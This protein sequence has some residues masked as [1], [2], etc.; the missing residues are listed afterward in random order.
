[1]LVAYLP[2]VLLRPRYPLLCLLAVGFTG[3]VLSWSWRHGRARRKPPVAPDPWSEPV[4]T[5]DPGEGRSVREGRPPRWRRAPETLP[6]GAYLFIAVVWF[7][8]IFAG[9]G[10]IALVV[11]LIGLED[12]APYLVPPIAALVL[13][14]LLFAIRHRRRRRPVEPDPW[15]DPKPL[16]RSFKTSIPIGGW[17]VIVALVCASLLCIAFVIAGVGEHLFGWFSAEFS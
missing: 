3:I 13:G 7:M 1:M 17:I 8:A 14:L 6:L 2:L 5:R 11:S 15:G 12:H 10:L 4:E 9:I 16:G